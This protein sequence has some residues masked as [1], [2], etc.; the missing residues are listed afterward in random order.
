MKTAQCRLRNGQGSSP[1]LV[2]VVLDP[3]HRLDPEVAGL[4][5]RL[6]FVG[7]SAICMQEMANSKKEG[8]VSVWSQVHASPRKEHTKTDPAD[9]AAPSWQKLA[10]HAVRDPSVQ[11][12]R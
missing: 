11:V 5:V 1:L 6:L 9:Q 4:G 8:R 3:K 12:G 7:S 2:H 10:V